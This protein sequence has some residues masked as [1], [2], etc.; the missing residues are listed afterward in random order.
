MPRYVAV[1]SV[2]HGQ[3]RGADKQLWSISKGQQFDPSE[4][5]MTDEAVEALLTRKQVRVMEKDSDIPAAK[6]AKAPLT[7]RSRKAARDDAVAQLAVQADTSGASTG[8]TRGG[9]SRTAAAA[10][11]AGGGST[12]G[13]QP[14]ATK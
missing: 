6:P 2:T 4:M 9:S 3:G 10:A 8:S 1:T 5:D 12:Q 14:P 7:A 13:G 11:A